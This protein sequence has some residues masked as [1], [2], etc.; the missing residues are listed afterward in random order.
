MATIYFTKTPP[1]SQ[2]CIFFSTEIRPW[3]KLELCTP[4]LVVILYTVAAGF[5]THVKNAQVVTNVIGN[6]KQTCIAILLVQQLVNRPM[7]VFTLLVP[8]Q[9][10]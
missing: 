7:S 3:N 5:A 8:M 1:T 6:L 2:A 4:S 9:F 10:C